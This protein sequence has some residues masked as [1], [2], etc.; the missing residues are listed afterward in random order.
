MPWTATDRLD[1]R[2]PEYDVPTELYNLDAV[3]YESLML[4]MFTIFRGERTFREKPND[5]VLG[6]SR[7]GF[8]WHR[9]DRRAFIGVSEH[10]GDWN[11]G[12][13]QSAGGVCLIVGDR[14]HFLPVE[15]Q[16]GGGGGDAVEAVVVVADLEGGHLRRAI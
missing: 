13:V 2:R 7:D 12:N 8:H 9:P 11:W 6:Y 15:A 16:E 10:V 4:G 14:L 1:P 5:I 3:G